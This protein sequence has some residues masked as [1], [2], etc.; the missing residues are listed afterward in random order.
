MNGPGAVPS[1]AMSTATDFAP[2]PAAGQ[3]LEAGDARELE[4]ARPGGADDRFGQRVL[5]RPLEAGGETQK[6]IFGDAVAGE[7]ETDPRPGVRAG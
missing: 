2:H 4:A 1:P 7:T 3:G 5:T 6:L